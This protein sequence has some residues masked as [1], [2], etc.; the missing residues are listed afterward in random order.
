VRILVHAASVDVT[1]R[2]AA[3]AAGLAM[4]GHQVTWC[5]GAACRDDIARLCAGLVPPTLDLVAPG[6]AVARVRPDLVLAGGSHRAVVG[7]LALWTG[8]D[9]LVLA[10]RGEDV[11]DRSLV[12][13][14]VWGRFR[15]CAL[16][17]EEDAAVARERAAPADLARFALWSDERVCG[18]ADAAHGDTE[19]LERACERALAGRRGG[20]ARPAVFLDRDGTLMVERGYLSDPEGVEL[21]PGV[22]EGLRRLR[23]AGFA[24]VVVSNQSGIGRGLFTLAQAHATMA[25]LRLLLR[26]R[27]AEPDAVWFCPHAPAAACACRKP[28]TALLERAAEDLGLSL[29]DSVMVGDKALDAETGRRAGGRGVLVRTGYGREEERRLAAAGAEHA[30]DHI[31]DGLLDAAA[32][33]VSRADSGG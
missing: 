15:A 19:V 25:R 9:T 2:M 1:S 21:L 22:P 20:A 24:L 28:G 11:G 18:Q 32:W 5:G 16:I 17:E 4:R 13:R 23:A 8:A 27:G 31:G 29:K 6:P 26:A 14:W 12:A 7:G 10:L 33:I 3:A 30:P